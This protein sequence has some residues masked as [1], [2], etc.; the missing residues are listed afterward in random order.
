MRILGM[1]L[2]LSSLVTS[3]SAQQVWPGVP[4]TRLWIATTCDTWNCA[5]AQ[6]IMA[7]GDPMTFTISS[8]NVDHPWVVVRQIVAG[9]AANVSADPYQLETF[10]GIATATARFA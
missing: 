1:A 6:L 5:A 7:N 4:L 9:S 8:G 3:A 10:D 2:I